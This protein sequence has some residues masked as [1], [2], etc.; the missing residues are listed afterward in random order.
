MNSYVDSRGLRIPYLLIERLHF[1]PKF[2]LHK[3]RIYA[4]MLVVEDLAT[5]VLNLQDIR[6]GSA[7]FNSRL[8]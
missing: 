7:V 6:I 3:N 8:P 5:V 1:A 2:L 4:K